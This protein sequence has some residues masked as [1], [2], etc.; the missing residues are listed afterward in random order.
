[1]LFKTI[2]RVGVPSSIPPGPVFCK[3][4]RVQNNDYVPSTGDVF[5]LLQSPLTSAKDSWILY[6]PSAPRSSMRERRSLSET[7]NSPSWLGSA[8][9][10]FTPLYELLAMS[11]GYTATQQGW[12]NG[13]P[14]GELYP[15]ET[16]AS[17]SHKQLTSFRGGGGGC[18]TAGGRTGIIHKPFSSARGVTFIVNE[19]LNNQPK[20]LQKKKK[21][22]F[23]NK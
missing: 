20:D 1:M 21:R 16:N 17:S 14:K 6:N 9:E 8:T 5:S 15:Q 3:A 2:Q 13:V 12:K 10:F 7:P 23:E 4:K 11:P 19:T 22:M 18:P